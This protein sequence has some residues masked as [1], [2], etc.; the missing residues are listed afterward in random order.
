MIKVRKAE[1]R[2]HANYGWLD[3]NHTFSF[4]TYYDPAHMGFRTLRVINEDRVEPGQGFGTHGH[5]DMEII[6]YVV[7]GALAHKDSSGGS[8]VLKPHEVQRMTAGTGIR[9]SEYNPSDEDRVHFYQ[10]WIVPEENGLEPGYEQT[11]FSPEEKK[12]K[13][14]LVASKGGDDGSVKINQDVALYA[15]ILGEGESVTHELAEG[16]HAW[17]QVIKG[18]VALN[19]VELDASDGAA[20]SEETRLEIESVADDSEILLFDLN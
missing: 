16:R 12:G 10:I 14:R 13:L 1:E 6:S 2:G 18:K 19:G 17:V 7:E 20:V 9:H 8:E 5:N 11:Y 3:T 4:N 15:S